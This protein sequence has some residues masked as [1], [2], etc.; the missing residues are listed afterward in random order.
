MDQED[1]GFFTKS[2]HSGKPKKFKG[3]PVAVP[4]YQTSTFSTSTIDE[5][6]EIYKGKEEGYTYTRVSNPTV[7]V[8][9]RRLAELEDAEDGCAFSSGMAAISTTMISLVKSGDNIVAAR[10]LY[11]GTLHL[12]GDI[13]PRMGI[14]ISFVDATNPQNVEET[15]KTNTKVVYVE[16][17]TNPLLEICDLSRIA[18]IAKK[19]NI[20]TVID[21]TIA[22]PYNQ[23][24]IKLS[25]DLAIHSAT[26]YLGGHDDLAAGIVVGSS[27]LISSIH[28]LNSYLG[29]ALDPHAGWLLLRGLM[30]LGL[31]IERQNQ[32]A[33]KTAE[34][35][36][37][38][39]MVKKV[40]YPGLVSHPQHEL[41]KKQMRG[42]GGLLSFEIKGTIETA[43]KFVNSLKLC[44]IA[45]SLGGVESLVTC[46]PLTSHRHIS[47]EQRLASGI[48]D[49]LVRLSVGIEDASD[50]IKDL[51]QAFK[52]I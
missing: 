27:E 26:K 4:I 36:A 15:I 50:I 32:N 20:T 17:P 35:L 29:G 38:N 12:F 43:K 21:N 5:V 3:E 16:S 49:E 47:R 37:S 8:V 2:V 44:K 42:F 13:L 45:A 24:P 10:G 51:D 6:S 1:W 39:K 25:F 48:V 14:T 41:A 30:T 52:Q 23:Q 31:R 7:K 46:P 19:R 34:F 11:G 18:S 9:E 22:T 33:M 28:K 40:H